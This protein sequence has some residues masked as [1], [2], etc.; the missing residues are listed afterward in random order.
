MG[1]SEWKS[2]HSVFLFS[3]MAKLLTWQDLEDALEPS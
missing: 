3:I 1:H 2:R